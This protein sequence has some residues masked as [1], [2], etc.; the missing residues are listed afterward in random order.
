MSA[1]RSTGPG[2]APSAASAPTGSGSENENVLP[3]PSSLSTQMRPPWCST[4]SLQIGRPRPVPF[5]LSV[6]VSPT[7][8]KRSNTLGWSAAAMPMPVSVTLTTSSPP[9]RTARQVTEPASV[10]LTAFE[11]RLMTTWIS[12]SRS[13]VTSGRSAAT[14]LTSLRPFC[15]KSDEV[16]A[17]ARS[18]TSPADTASMCHSSLPA[19]IL[20][21]SS[22]S[23]ISLVSRS[24]SL[25]TTLRLSCTCAMVCCT[26]LS[27]LWT[28]GKM[29][30]SSRFLMILA[31]PSTE[32]SGVRSSWLTVERNALL[33]ASA[34][35][36]AARARS[37]SS[38]SRR[39]S[40]SCSFSCR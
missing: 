9:R 28:S 19:S 7:C 27:S 12:R 3:V 36:A 35:S 2:A 13:P 33:A 11:I 6:S 20:A 10:N 5:G 31:K 30:S 23:S 40:C 18:M 39:F 22:T 37:A 38:N 32:V 24:P 21:R 16:A 8:L 25:T 17:V 15:S 26:F 1:A 29:R 34:S 4:I 14:S